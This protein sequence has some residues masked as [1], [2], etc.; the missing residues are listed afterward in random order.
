MRSVRR[1]PSFAVADDLELEDF[2]RLKD[3]RF[4]DVWVQV[5][6]EILTKWR[7]RAEPDEPD[8]PS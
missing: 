8:Q 3:D 7:L 5:V 6:Q 1:Y 4:Y 2:T